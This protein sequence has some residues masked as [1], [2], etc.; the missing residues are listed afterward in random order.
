[1]RN[2]VRNNEVQSSRLWL[3]R[4]EAPPSKALAHHGPQATFGSRRSARVAVLH[5]YR[6]P[7]LWQ[8]PQTAMLVAYAHVSVYLNVGS[9][10]GCRFG[11]RVQVGRREWR[12]PLQRS[13]ARKCRESA[14]ESAA[15][16]FG[17]QGSSGATSQ[18]G[19]VQVRSRLSEL[20]NL[21]ANKRPDVHEHGHGHCRCV[22]A[23]GGSARRHCSRDSRRAARPGR[24]GR[25]R[26][27]HHLPGGQRYALDSDDSAG[28]VGRDCVY[29]ARRDLPCTAAFAAVTDPAHS[30]TLTAP[31]DALRRGTRRSRGRRGS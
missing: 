11:D 24:A 28:F 2:S 16:L 15:D 10:H 7:L 3:R 19:S 23:T 9:L 31:R 27:V 12:R 18:A 5:G 25:W 21:G 17:S 20:R 4:A 14:V 1:M 22:G 13:T 6:H 8:S 30:T 26:S 29:V